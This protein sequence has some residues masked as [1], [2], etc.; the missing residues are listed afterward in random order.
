MR[1]ATALAKGW[2]GPVHPAPVHFWSQPDDDDT[3]DMALSPGFPSIFKGQT[4]TIGTTAECV[5]RALFRG[6]L[7]LVDMPDHFGNGFAPSQ[8]SLDLFKSH[9]PAQVSGLWPQGKQRRSCY[10][11]CS[12]Y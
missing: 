5:G 3:D 1:S 7:E 10:D 9:H 4:F 2:A 11:S 6:V 12:Q 8:P